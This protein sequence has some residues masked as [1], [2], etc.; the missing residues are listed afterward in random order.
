M[1][2]KTAGTMINTILRTAAV[3]TTLAFCAA[4]AQAQSLDEPA[5]PYLKSQTT[6]TGSIVR[7]GDLVENA[8]VIANVA[9]FRAPDLGM[10]GVVPAEAV[11][12][13]VREHALVGLDTAGLSEV[14]V[15]RASREIPVGEIEQSVARAL[16]TRY[17]LGTP[18]DISV[19]FEREPRSF[20]VEANA[21]GEPRVSRLTYN[22]SNGRFD[23]AL[24]IPTGPSQY[25]V[26]RLSGHAAVTAD[27]VMVT[28][29]IEK[30][31]V[32]RA[33]DLVIA[34]RPRA[35]VG[36]DALVDIKQAAGLA[37]RA[38]LR[39]GQPIKSADLTKPEIIRRN[40]TVT[41]LYEVP[42]ITLSVRGKA[43]DG[44][45]EGDHISVLN[46]Q[47]KRTVQGVIAGPGHV[48]VM[49]PTPRLA[50]NTSQPSGAA[51]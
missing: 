23:A 25:G 30:N 29:T 45:A 34:R 46:E 37:A 24:E 7:I 35:E 49:S 1:T 43:V 38:I 33:K 18:A 13:A 36:H 19:R 8:G 26:L 14:V 27:V 16:S 11:V 39:P 48:I 9:V 15:T 41:L 47:S 6:V 5:R 51:R 22:A 4:T 12:E 40:E 17:N 28:H 2:I 10:T 21:K 42:G 50:A 44:G 3:A 32:L 20:Q 31:A